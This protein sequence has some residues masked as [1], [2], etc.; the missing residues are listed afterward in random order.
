MKKYELKT[1]AK[2]PRLFIGRKVFFQLREDELQGIM[3]LTPN[4]LYTFIDW[5]YGFLFIIKDDAGRECIISLR[6]EHKCA[7][8]NFRT[9]WQLHHSSRGK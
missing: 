3:G 8:L 4:K 5:E 6:L 1:M 2:Y 9:D 7:H